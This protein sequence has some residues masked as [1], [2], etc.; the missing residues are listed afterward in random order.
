MSGSP[1]PKINPLS[2]RCPSRKLLEL[3][4]DKWTVLLIAALSR[5]VNR[6]GRLLNEIGGISQKMLTQTLRKLVGQ[7]LVERI[8]YHTVPPH[9][10]YRLT[11]LGE[12]LV[13]PI[14]VLGRW[15]EEHYHEVEWAQVRAEAADSPA[16]TEVRLDERRAS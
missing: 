9:V 15:V 11:P 1:R 2:P 16:A 8:D 3:L 14:H 7:G 10:E 13:E 4:A 12:T 6:N 5:G